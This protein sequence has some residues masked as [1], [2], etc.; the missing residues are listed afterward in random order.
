MLIG[1]ST[2]RACA[3]TK[4][5]FTQGAL[6]AGPGWT[7]QWCSQMYRSPGEQHI[8]MHPWGLSGRAYSKSRGSQGAGTKALGLTLSKAQAPQQNC[9]P[10]DAAFWREGHI[11]TWGERWLCSVVMESSLPYDVVLTIILLFVPCTDFLASLYLLFTNMWVYVHWRSQK[12]SAAGNQ[13][14]ALWVL[15]NSKESS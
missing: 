8:T 6:G 10:E 11:H 7:A 13:T 5:E 15:W 12:N 14:W 2:L 4:E 1:P 9:H 3:Y